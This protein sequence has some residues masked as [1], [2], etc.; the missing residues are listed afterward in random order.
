M[1]SL[2]SQKPTP[3]CLPKIARNF[4]SVFA[5]LAASSFASAEQTL[6]DFEADPTILTGWHASA[7][8]DEGKGE[9]RSAA[10]WQKPFSFVLDSEK[11]HSGSA[12][13]KCEF[14]EDL[15]GTFSFGTPVLPA[16][17]E[18]QIR[19]FVRTSNFADKEGI[20]AV[21]EYDA[22]KNRLKGNR[23]TALV[24]ASDDW[25]EVSW[26]SQLN[27]ETASISLRFFYRSAS[28][29][30]GATLWMDDLS[31]NPVAK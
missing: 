6:I 20:I 10:K 26:I 29:E 15:Q 1:I 2:P 7:T 23:V 21:E 16:S 22:S 31:V 18:V 30:T 14:S 11:P 13:L 3:H 28:I 9:F 12:S 4:L 5:L 19:F 27:P 24:P 8:G 17:G 25:T